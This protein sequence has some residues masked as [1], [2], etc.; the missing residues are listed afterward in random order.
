[1][2]TC[3]FC[4]K[5]FPMDED[6]RCHLRTGCPTQTSKPSRRDKEESSLSSGLGFSSFGGNGG[7][8]DDFG[9]S[10]GGGDFGGGGASDDF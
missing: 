1:M 5:Y 2:P 8:D 7:G 9:G 6:L 10:S 3:K 4:K